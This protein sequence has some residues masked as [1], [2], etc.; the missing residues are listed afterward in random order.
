MT[1][2]KIYCSFES[3]NDT[4]GRV[5]EERLCDFGEVG[6]VIFFPLELWEKEI[7]TSVEMRTFVVVG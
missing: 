2:G 7:L 4:L 6:C 3:L 5:I 1:V